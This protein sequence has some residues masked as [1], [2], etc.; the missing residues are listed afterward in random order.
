LM[1]LAITHTPS[2]LR[3][4]TILYQ[5]AALRGGRLEE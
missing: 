5:L 3:P 1:R 2:F 4:A